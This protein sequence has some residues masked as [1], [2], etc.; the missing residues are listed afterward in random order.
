LLQF[1]DHMEQ[2]LNPLLISQR[3]SAASSRKQWG[4]ICAAPNH[5]QQD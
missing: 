2:G 1:L 4:R 5:N 3:Q